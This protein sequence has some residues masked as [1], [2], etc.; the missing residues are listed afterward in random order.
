MFSFGQVHPEMPKLTRNKG[1][2]F[3][4]KNYFYFCYNLKLIS[5]LLTNRNVFQTQRL[6][7]FF[8]SLTDK[9]N[10]MKE[11]LDCFNLIQTEFSL[12]VSSYWSGVSK[13]AHNC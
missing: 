1:F 5:D 13:F 6:K 9:H 8:E 12:W 7:V 2:K 10:F 3:F 4:K 11:L